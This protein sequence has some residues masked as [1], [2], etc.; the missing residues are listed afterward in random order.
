MLQDTR[1]KPMVG[2]F[3]QKRLLEK[4]MV[5][6][7]LTEETTQEGLK[8]DALPENFQLTNFLTPIHLLNT[9]PYQLIT[10]P[11][12][13]LLMLVYLCQRSRKPLSEP[14]SGMKREYALGRMEWPGQCLH[15]WPAFM[16][17]THVRETLQILHTGK[18][19]S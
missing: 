16:L 9:F 13:C 12:N 8:G 2:Y 7:C 11:D 10:M 18:K 4:Q 17:L 3:S 19:G 5:T 1:L 14:N 15:S 6:M